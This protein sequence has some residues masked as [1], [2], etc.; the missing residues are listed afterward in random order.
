M[1]DD[2]FWRDAS[3]R[4]TFDLA[5]VTAVDYPAV[6]REIVSALS[7]IPDDAP[8]FG[9]QQIFWDFTS[10]GQSLGL[11]WDIWMGLMVVAKSVGSEALVR[12]I[13]EWLRASHWAKAS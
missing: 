9:P 7:L 11:D 13:A 2:R 4:L 10:Q 5:G 6:C 8:I 12:E 1:P 3:G